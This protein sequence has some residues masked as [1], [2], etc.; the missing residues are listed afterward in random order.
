[1]W[2]GVSA[3]LPNSQTENRYVK[4]KQEA[5]AEGAGWEKVRS[6]KKDKIPHKQVSGIVI[7]KEG[8][9]YTEILQAVKGGIDPAQL[10]AGAKVASIRRSGNEDLMIHV[11]VEG[12]SAEALCK[13]VEEKFPELSRNVQ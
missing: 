1:M 12:K 7:S 3:S 6:R 2:A 13:A 4:D 5:D 9:T 8:K 10:P 11:K